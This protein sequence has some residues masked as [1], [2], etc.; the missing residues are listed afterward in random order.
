MKNTAIARGSVFIDSNGGV[1]GLHCPQCLTE[2]RDGFFQCADCKVPLKP[3]KP[4]IKPAI[5]PA[6]EYF[7]QMVGVLDT[8][9]KFALASA[10]TALDQAEIVY[11]IV[12][13]AD[14]PDS[15]KVTN[16]TWW[17][18]PSRILV[19]AEDEAEAR[20]LVERFQAPIERSNVADAPDRNRLSGSHSPETR[21]RLMTL[22]RAA[23][24]LGVPLGAIVVVE[25]L[26]YSE[27]ISEATIQSLSSLFIKCL[28]V[29][30]FFVGVGVIVDTARE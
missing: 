9:D 6:Q 8:N 1:A 23:L 14:V 22:P 19:S 30:V 28:I 7:P 2:Y 5:R 10:A 15:L 12:P 4:P 21:W 13:I 3:G 25:A 26:Y 29:G 17:V 27:V 16:P 18:R 24:I 11:D 20:A